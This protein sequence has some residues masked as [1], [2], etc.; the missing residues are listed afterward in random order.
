MPFLRLP[1]SLAEPSPPSPPPLL[2]TDRGSDPDGAR[3]DEGG[4]SAMSRADD[5]SFIAGA[6]AGGCAVL[7]LVAVGV[8]LYRRRVLRE[9][10]AAVLRSGAA[11]PPPVVKRRSISL[12][13]SLGRLPGRGSSASDK[14]PRAAAVPPITA[15][16]HATMQD[17]LDGNASPSIAD[18]LEGAAAKEARASP[19]GTI[20]LR[21][22]SR[23]HSSS[24]YAQGGAADAGKGGSSTAEPYLHADYV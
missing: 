14:E 21:Q 23:V 2:G 4:E 3:I 20:Q 19:L 1:P 15:T 7:L 24:I 8:V 17:P 5:G 18:R 12:K 10:A 11:R 16:I 13:V 22:S 9:R 6:A